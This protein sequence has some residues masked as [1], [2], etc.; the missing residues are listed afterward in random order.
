MLQN[1]ILVWI[2][3]NLFKCKKK[4]KQKTFFLLLGHTKADGWLDLAYG[5]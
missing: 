2:F 5:P 4:S 1:S 3:F